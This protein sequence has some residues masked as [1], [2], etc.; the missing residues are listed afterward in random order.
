MKV[1]GIAATLLF[2]MSAD[3]SA[4]DFRPTD[5]AYGIPLQTNGAVALYEFT[6]PDEVYRGIT[7]EDL[8]DICMFNGQEE[9]IPFALR[10]A[11][12]PASPDEQRQLPLFPVTAKQSREQADLSLRVKRGAQGSIISVETSDPAVRTHGITSYLLDASSLKTA[13]SGLVLDWREHPEGTVAKLK[14]EGSNDLQ[15]RTV[16]VPSVTILRLNY[17]EHSLERR[18]IETGG[19]RMNYYRIS[20]TMASEPPRLV[21]AFARLSAPGRE[22]TRHW[23]RLSTIPRSGRAGEYLFTMTGLMPVDRI[24]VR[25]PQENTLVQA[26]FFSRA[27]E[28]DPWEAGP[29]VLLYRLRIRGEEI[30]SPDIVLP[31]SSHR[32]RLLHIELGGG[33]IGKGLPLVELGWVPDRVLF[34]ARGGSPFRLAYGSGRT[35]GCKRGDDTLFRQF[36][37][38]QK[39]GYE[40]GFAEPGSPALL[41]GKA[42]L[43]KPLLP[44]DWKTVILWSSLLL[45]VG[46]LAWMAVR[47]HRQMNTSKGDEQ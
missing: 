26:A 7:R 13:V 35:D 16:I 45:G 47:L 1:F 29:T 11:S 39:E 46:L 33:G 3:V 22:R 41:G 31:E 38:Q 40:I 2:L 19:S 4:R 15:R 23:L 32:Y 5:F 10:R 8:G 34:L 25:L 37:D 6:L 28:R 24:R 18:V 21:S 20:S 14:V 42:A 44:S 36:S 27:S 12:L 30:T 17:G 43:R 9:V